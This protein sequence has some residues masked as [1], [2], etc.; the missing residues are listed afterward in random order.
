MTN[1]PAQVEYLPMVVQKVKKIKS[2]DTKTELRKIEKLFADIA[3]D[4]DLPTFGD[5]FM[6]C[7]LLGIAENVNLKLMYPETYLKLSVF[8]AEHRAMI[9]AAQK[10]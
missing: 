9:L 7:I 5:F 3:K 8:L 1:F 4:K 10:E 2:Y 6:E